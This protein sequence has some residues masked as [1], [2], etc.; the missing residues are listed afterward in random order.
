MPIKIKGKMP[1]WTL[2][3]HGF[4]ILTD[5]IGNRFR[6]GVRVKYVGK[7]H[8][9]MQ[10]KKFTARNYVQEYDRKR[11]RYVDTI[12]LDN[13]VWVETKEVFACNLETK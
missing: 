11:R 6:I 13:G 5:G 9:E 4:N 8:P 7:K 1:K 2:D 12:E 3:A 10:F